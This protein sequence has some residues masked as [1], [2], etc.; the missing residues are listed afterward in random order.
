MA[1]KI[2]VSRTGRKHVPVFRIVAVDSRKKRDGKFLENLGTYDPVRGQII[3]FH[4]ERILDWMSK[5]AIVTDVVKRLHK[6]FIIAKGGKVAALPKK[7][8]EVIVKEVVPA[9]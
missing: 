6:K 9:E 3:Q 1:V 5:G 8:K 4:E 7:V 2:R